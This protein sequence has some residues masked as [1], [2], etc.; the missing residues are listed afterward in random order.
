M[1]CS[2]FDPCGGENCIVAI[3]LAGDYVHEDDVFTSA[4]LP[5][6]ETC[7]SKFTPAQDGALAAHFEGSEELLALCE[8]S[9]WKSYDTNGAANAAGRCA[10]FLADSAVDELDLGDHELYELPEALR[11]LAP[12]VRVLW[13][14]DNHF[15]RIPDWIGDF[16]KLEILYLHNLRLKGSLPDALHRTD[17][18]KI[19]V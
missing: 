13:L 19:V 12:R 6:R 18:V 1:N 9:T 11:F 2:A 17:K 10:E 5:V 14:N 8:P 16:E 15:T 7:D 4:G 3:R